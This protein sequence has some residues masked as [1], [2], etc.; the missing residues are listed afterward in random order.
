MLKSALYLEFVKYQTPQDV[1]EY[2]EFV[3]KTLR[4]VEYLEDPWNTEKFAE[5]FEFAINTLPDSLLPLRIQAG[6]FVV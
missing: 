2:F 4:S 3:E 5:Y 1:A 6:T